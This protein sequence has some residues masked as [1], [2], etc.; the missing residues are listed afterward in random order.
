MKF[1]ENGSRPQPPTSRFHIM[2]N[3]CESARTRI[4]MF[5]WTSAFWHQK[6]TG[7]ILRIYIHKCTHIHAH[8][9]TRTHTHAHTHMFICVICCNVLQGVAGCCRVLQCGAKCWQ[10]ANAQMETRTGKHLRNVFLQKMPRQARRNLRVCLD[11][12][13]AIF[14]AELFAGHRDMSA[15]EW[16][17]LKVKRDLS[18]IKTDPAKVKRD[19]RAVK[20]ETGEQS[21][22]TQEQSKETCAQSKETLS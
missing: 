10:H 5:L 20:R 6:S 11:F 2:H 8:T 21:K 12:C 13:G 19:R 22:E 4:H 16:D 17:L 9:L 1:L 15:F 18:K 3:T 7:N 14:F